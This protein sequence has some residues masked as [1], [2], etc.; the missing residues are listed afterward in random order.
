MKKCKRGTIVYL[1]I[2][3]LTIDSYLFNDL[4]VNFISFNVQ[5]ELDLK[6]INADRQKQIGIF[7]NSSELYNSYDY[8]DS[9]GTFSSNEEGLKKDEVTYKKYVNFLFKKQGTRFDETGIKVSTIPW[10]IKVFSQLTNYI[11]A[12]NSEYNQYSLKTL[13]ENKIVDKKLAYINAEELQFKVISILQGYVIRKNSNEPPVID[14]KEVDSANWNVLNGIRSQQPESHKQFDNL[15]KERARILVTHEFESNQ[16]SELINSTFNT[17][18]ENNQHK[19]LI[20]K[21]QQRLKML[22]MK[23]LKI[24]AKISKV[25][26]DIDV[27]KGKDD[28]APNW[29]LYVEDHYG[30]CF[31]MPSLAFRPVYYE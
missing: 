20:N 24:E 21:T 16:L 27:R 30:N 15:N 8:T 17:V 23:L 5:I 12:N 9:S 6:L 19:I 18:P 4:F 14:L 7:I 22:N 3:S 13:V 31:I 11:K 28:T 10:C 1:N 2:E 29:F 25:K 26:Q